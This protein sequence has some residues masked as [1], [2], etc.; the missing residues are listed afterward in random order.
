MNVVVFVNGVVILFTAI[1][2]AVDAVMFPSTAA[3]F[4]SAAILSGSTGLFLLIAARG[5]LHSF[6]RLHGFILTTSVWLIGALA[7]AL[8]LWLWGLTPVDAVFE[9]MS[10]ITTTGSTVMSGLDATPRGVLFWRALL[11]MMGG[12]GFV[13]TAMA[14]LPVL[15][16]GG[17]QLYRTESSEKGEKEFRTAAGYALATLVVYV[18]LVG[19]ATATYWSGGMSPFDAATHAMTTLSTGGYSNYDA[20]F[21]HFESPFLHWSATLFMLAGALPFAWYIRIYTRGTLQS[22]QV[23][24]FLLS[25]GAVIAVLTFWLWLARDVPPLDAARLVS[26]NVVSI[27][28]T[29]GYA[30]QDYTAWGSVAAVFFFMLTAVGGCT[31]STA[32]GAKA[33]RWVVLF[34]SL[35][36]RIRSIGLPNSVYVTRYE[37]RPVSDDVLAGVMSFFFFYALTVGLVAIVLGFFGLD[38]ITALSA[39]LTAVANVG[40]GIGSIV[41]PAGNFADLPDLAKTVL[42]FA[43]YAGRLEMLTLYVLFLP[44][45]WRAL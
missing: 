45:F 22:E 6:D 15:Q 3:V 28:T 29:T 33:M 35:H 19:L 26:F 5:S 9:A 10:G 27:V 39:S 17:M 1:L 7:G 42:T 25:V 18:G 20:S 14:L 32:G 2:M 8:P 21:G 31:G 23:S 16:V 12:V 38:T 30:T 44:K 40:P 13:V 11:Q 37:G 24:S 36:L 4:S 34:R 43:M 41:G